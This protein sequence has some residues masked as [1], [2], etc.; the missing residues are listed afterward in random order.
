MRKEKKHKLLWEARFS[1]NEQHNP[2]DNAL[3]AMARYAPRFFGAASNG[4]VRTRAPEGMRSKRSTLA[5]SPDQDR[6]SPRCGVQEPCD[7][8]NSTTPNSVSCPTA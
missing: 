2:F 8:V 3:P 4:L 6:P 1:V 7:S 5:R